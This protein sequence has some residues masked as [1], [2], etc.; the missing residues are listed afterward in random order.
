MLPRNGA[1]LLLMSWAIKVENMNSC[2]IKV[3]FADLKKTPA[4][5]GFQIT[6]VKYKYKLIFNRHLKELGKPTKRQ[7]RVTILILMNLNYR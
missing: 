1:L 4:T 6:R 3:W 7:K 5:T 2:K